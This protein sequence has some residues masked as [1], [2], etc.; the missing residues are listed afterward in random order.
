MPALSAVALCYCSATKCKQ[1]VPLA[2]PLAT[3]QNADMNPASHYP[4]FCQPLHSHWPLPHALAG[5]QLVSCQFAPEQVQPDDV[6][7]CGIPTVKGASKRQAEYL[8]GRLCARQALL[9]LTGTANVPT[10]G[11]DRAPSWP[12][13]VT[14]SITHGQRWAAAIVAAKSDYQGLGLDVEKWLSRARAERLA[15]QILTP[16]ELQR[17]TQL[18]IA[19]QAA[20]I[21][22]TFSL[23]ESLFKALYPLVQQRF[24]FQQAELLFAAEGQAELQL[25]TDLSPRW[26]AGSRCQGQFVDLGEQLLSL[27]SIGA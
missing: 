22:L 7:L 19:E 17:L 9:Q 3:R 6:A 25:L 26:P 1:P 4:R 13:G 2:A 15:V 24:Y 12:E 18:P 11:A 5:A 21:S 27:V 20:R 8:A 14:G 10:V 23:K 16:A